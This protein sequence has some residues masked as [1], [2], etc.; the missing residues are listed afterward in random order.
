MS[1][2]LSPTFIIGSIRFGTV[3]EASAVNFGNSLQ[4]DFKN[5]K[6]HNQGFGSVDGDNNKID[7][8]KSVL[9][10]PDFV[11]M[12]NLDN[13]DIPDWMRDMITSAAKKLTEDEAETEET[14]KKED[15]PANA[16]DKRD[17]SGAS[18]DSE[19]SE[20]DV[21]TDEAVPQELNDRHEW[22]TQETEWLVE[23]AD[24]VIQSDEEREESP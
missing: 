14:G 5:N 13:S 8:A 6:K 4:V 17:R 18:F 15:R 21:R 3:S 1:L 9:H 7:G 11:D 10:D 23:E 20:A 16:C 12:M 24:W 2:S 19:L 22:G